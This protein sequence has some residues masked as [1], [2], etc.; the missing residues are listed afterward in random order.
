MSSHTSKRRVRIQIVDPFRAE[1]KSRTR[2][3]R[4][5][6]VSVDRKTGIMYCTCE[7]ALYRKNKLFPDLLSPETEMC[8]HMRRL[9][10]AYRRHGVEI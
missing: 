5:H 2:A 6:Q 7:D 8:E 1:C 9:R 10:Q 3:G 4:T